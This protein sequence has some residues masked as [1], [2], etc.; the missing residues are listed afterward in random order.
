[1]FYGSTRS[2]ASYSFTR[3]VLD[4]LMEDG[5]LSVPQHVPNFESR[6][7][8]LASLSY[9][10]LALVLMEPYV[11]EPTGLTRSD[12]YEVLTKAY[13][14]EVFQSEEIT[15]VLSLGGGVHLL[16]VSNGPTLAF[17]DIA[18][19]F[20]GHLFEF[21]LKRNHQTMNILGAT[22]GDTGSAAEYAFAN[23]QG[24][25]IFMLSPHDRMSRFQ[26]AQM[27]SLLADNIFN[28]AIEG[29]FDDCQDLVKLVNQNQ[30]F[31]RTH[32]IGAV[33]SINWGRILAQMVYYF[34]GVL[35]LK[36]QGISID[37]GVDVCVPSGNFGNAYAA[38]L[39]KRMGLPIRRIVVATNENDVLDEFFRTG[40][41]R[42]RPASQTL[43]T[44]SPSM[45]IS[46]ASNFERC[47]YDWVGADETAR[48]WR[49][50][51]TQG[52]FDLKGMLKNIQKDFVSGSSTH[53]DRI[54]T[55]G[56]VYHENKRV[57]DPHTADGVKVAKEKM[58]ECPMLVVETAL[59]VKFNETVKE[60]L[61]FS[62]PYPTHLA[63][64]ETRPQK[65]TVLPVDVEKLS[66]FIQQQ[67][68]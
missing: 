16:Q 51:E 6:L 32:R 20:L 17:K 5:G 57:I 24:I 9:V 64:I 46:K 34:K 30:N 43:A 62:L 54:K 52:F 41:Y 31:K 63:D 21:L 38:F 25:N 26:R 68:G 47:V 33:N 61:G 59:A 14:S 66:S 45:D 8:E 29:V 37:C 4:G 65:V 12:L 58:D 36:K 3:V 56:Q 10:E 50:L 27:Y 1:M 7:A 11:V 35:A 53:Q 13:R 44:S 18:M 48:C 60:A 22:S 67:I 15:P 42:P 19:Q 40:I 39:A 28:V 2:H 49:L 23:K 55:I